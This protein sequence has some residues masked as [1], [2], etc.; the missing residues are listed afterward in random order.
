MLHIQTACVNNPEFI[1][2]QKVLFDRFM[3]G[4]YDFT[5]FNHAKD[6]PDNSNYFDTSNDYRNKIRKTCEKLNIQCVD[7]FDDP[8]YK[9]I[10]SSGTAASMNFILNEYHKP[11]PGKYFVTDSDMFL[12][13]P[14]GSDKYDDYDAV[15]RTC[16]RNEYK[17]MWNGIYYFD[18]IRMKNM[19][20]LNWN[21]FEYTKT[22]PHPGY[23][24][25]T[26]TGGLT[27]P[28]V[29]EESKNHKTREIVMLES[30][31]WDKNDV[32]NEFPRSLI[33]FCE[34]DSRRFKNGKYFPEV[35]ENVI[36]HYRA[37]GNWE[38]RSKS[39]HDTNKNKL[40]KCLYDLI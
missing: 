17:Y 11:N 23:G 21:Q 6:Y 37:G 27:Y 34:N 9:G 7:I 28:W 20:L 18:T 26:D 39:V 15:Y 16:V 2:V 24:Y 29:H 10:P 22:N 32:S 31:G 1:E 38:N 4:N 33:D 13:G 8:W 19:D 35:Y 40:L 12:V 14:M 30:G 36:F 5:V 3:T 25:W